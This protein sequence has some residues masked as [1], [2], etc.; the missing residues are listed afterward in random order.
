L[1]ILMNCTGGN[2]FIP[3]HVIWHFAYLSLVMRLWY[4]HLLCT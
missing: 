3:M 1:K 2:R 4:F